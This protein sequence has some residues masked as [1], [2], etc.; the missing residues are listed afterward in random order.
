MLDLFR[1]I[2]DRLSE[3]SR[4]FDFREGDEARC[5]TG[6]GVLSLGDATE[7]ER[8]RVLDCLGEGGA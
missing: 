3:R 6:D 5:L 1:S 8:E 4:V 7:R 2:D